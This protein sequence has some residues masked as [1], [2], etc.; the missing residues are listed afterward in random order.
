MNVIPTGDARLQRMEQAALWLQRIHAAADDEQVLEAWLDWCQRDPMN[1]QAF[2]ELAVVWELGG[3]VGA[4]A[5]A[6][7]AETVRAAASGNEARGGWTRRGALA[8]SLAALVASGV[9]GLWWANRHSAQEVAGIDFSSPTGVNSVQRLPDGSVLELGGGTHVT[10]LMDERRRRVQLHEGEVYVAVKKD[11]GRPFS[12][13][14]GRL[15]AI[16]TGTAFNVLRTEGRVTV[17][18][19][20]GSVEAHYDQN[21]SSMPRNR[22]QP[23]QQLVYWHGSHNVDVRNVDPQLAIAWR[24]GQLH[25]EGESLSEVIATVNRYAPRPIVIE[26]KRVAALGYS[27]TVNVDNIR[28]FL[29]GLQHSFHVAVVQLP[30]GRQRID[31]RPGIATD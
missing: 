3:A 10:V 29:N 30:D 2:D 20:E 31:A 21:I 11:A 18:V 12:V 28:G 9:A 8:A 16:A 5:P 6:S 4:D 27:G 13:Q 14:A 7:D 15:E 19:A 22:L 23:H 24:K 25:Y 1:Q 26:D 17:T